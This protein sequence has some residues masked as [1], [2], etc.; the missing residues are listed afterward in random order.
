MRRGSRLKG[1][2]KRCGLPF[3]QTAVFAAMSWQPRMGMAELHDDCVWRGKML[4]YRGPKLLT[5]LGKSEHSFEAESVLVSFWW[6]FKSFILCFSLIHPGIPG[7]GAV[8]W[9]TT[10]TFG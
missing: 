2:R 8:V 3:G 4:V 10:L 9:L 6:Q 1:Y 5:F 7:M